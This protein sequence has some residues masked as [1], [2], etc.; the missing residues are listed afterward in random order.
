MISTVEAWVLHKQVSGDTSL[1]IDFF[2]RDYGLIRCLYKGGRTLKK[3]NVI[4]LF[5]PLHITFEK[6][7][8]RF[9]IKTIESLTLAS[10]LQGDALFCAYYINEILYYS[11]K[12]ELA[13]PLLFD[14]YQQVMQAL[15]SN[16]QRLILESLLRRFEWTLIHACGYTF[17]LTKDIQGNDLKADQYYLFNPGQGFVAHPTGIPGAHLLALANDDLEHFAHLKS[18]KIIMRQAIDHLLDGRPIKARSLFA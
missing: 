9:Y 13:D 16:P 4:H 18:A 17:S 2:C 12:P 3:N 10:F 6:R 15:T 11:L 7:Y 5:T 8:D 1:W 14:A